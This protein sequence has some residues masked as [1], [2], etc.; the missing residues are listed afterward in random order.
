MPCIL[1]VFQSGG[2]KVEELADCVCTNVAL[3]ARISACVQTS[4]EFKDQMSTRYRVIPPPLFDPSSRV[5]MG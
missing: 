5:L 4:C 3:Q 2:C 1:E